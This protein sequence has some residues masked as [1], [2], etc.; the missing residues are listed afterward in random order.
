MTGIG[1]HDRKFLQRLDRHGLIRAL[2]LLRRQDAR[3]RESNPEAAQYD[4]L[5]TAGSVRA[6]YR[7]RGWKIPKPTRAEQAE[8]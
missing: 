3:P 4:G 7:R 8:R 6:E 1:D 2:R 5:A